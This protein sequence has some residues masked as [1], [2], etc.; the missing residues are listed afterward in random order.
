MIVKDKE[1][2]LKGQVKTAEQRQRAIEL[3]EMLVGVEKVTDSLTVREAD[4]AV[5]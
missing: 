5:K 3:A 4:E 1:V 2:E